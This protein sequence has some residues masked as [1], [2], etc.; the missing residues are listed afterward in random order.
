MSLPNTFLAPHALADLP[1]HTPLLLALSGGADSCALL[2]MLAV[3][4]QRNGTPLSL[5]HVDHGIRGEES[6]RDREFCRALAEKYSL[7]FYLHIVNIPKL[8]HENGTGLEEEAR[9]V[10]YAFFTSV[11]KEQ[12]IP[13][14]VT[15]HHAD[16]NAETM[17]FRLA[18]GTSAS[19]L[20]GIPSVRDCE[21]G[22]VVR[23]LLHMTKAEIL[24]YCKE[25]D[26]AFMTDST[27]ESLNYARNRIRHT[28][29]PALQKIN[30]NTV[31]NMT[32]LA[33]TLTL[34]EDFWMRETQ[35]YVGG[36]SLAIA[37]LLLLHPA[38]IARC[39]VSF[40]R[41]NGIEPSEI[42]IAQTKALMQSGKEHAALC[43]SGG[44][45]TKEAGTLIAGAEAP[46]ASDY[47]IPLQR[48]LN[49]ILDGK[50]CVLW[51]TNNDPSQENHLLC[52]NI[53][54][55]A[56][57]VRISFD[58]I[59]GSL[60]VR[61]RRERDTLLCGGMHKKVKKLLCDHKIPLSIRNTL[62]L[63][64]DKGGIV[65]IPLVAP[66]DGAEAKNGDVFTLYYNENS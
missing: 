50:L 42:A 14:L 9:R 8:A 64:C 38:L 51:E 36:N 48:G 11:M 34:E 22:K 41:Q 15:A 55:K 4:C 28:V 6:M 37:P 31:Q 29:L 40:L 60:F 16:D 13:I 39:I 45:L 7:P 20:C 26:L 30:E 54:K 44:I 58:T 61:P 66:R 62:P 35:K 25:N 59:N 65:W 47:C 56:T 27:N 53:Y 23:P 3:Y 24:G 19:G 12:N 5:A 10:R 1:K 32:H 43:L 46:A 49:P 17:L 52:Q 57:K 18:R 63:L 21:G 2:H 33:D